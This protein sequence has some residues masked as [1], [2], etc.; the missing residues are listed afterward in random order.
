[1]TRPISTYC[2]HLMWIQSHDGGGD[3]FCDEGLPTGSEKC[4]EQTEQCG[5]FERGVR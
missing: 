4:I 2:K 5:W 3:Y 1:M